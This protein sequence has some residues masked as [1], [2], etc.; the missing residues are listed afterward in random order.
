[1]ALG[2]GTPYLYSFYAPQLL[3]K[4][5]LPVSNL[6]TLSLSMNLGSSLL[7]FFAGMVIDRNVAA[8]CLIGAICTFSAYWILH[9]CYVHELGSVP[10]ISFGLSLVGFG[11]VS[12]Y[13]AAVKCCTTNFPHHRGTA[14]SFP[15]ALYAL[16]G[17][18]FASICTQAF[19]DDIEKIFKFLMWVCSSMIFVGCLTLRIVASPEKVRAKKRKSSVSQHHPNLRGSDNTTSESVTQPI[20]INNSSQDNEPTNSSYQTDSQNRMSSL[21]S[22]SSSSLASSFQSM[23]STKRSDSFLWSKD[24]TGSLS[25]WGWGRVRDENVEPSTPQTP[26]PTFPSFPLSR[27]RP[28]YSSTHSSPQHHRLDSFTKVDRTDSFLRDQTGAIILQR[29]KMNDDVTN[30]EELTR[31]T[32]ETKASSW[33][34][35][36]VFRTI[37][38]P[39]FLVY[40]VILATLQGIGQ[41]YI[42]SVGFIVQTQVISTPPGDYNLNPEKIQSLQV[43]II[44]I[45]SFLGR[46]SSGPVSDLLVK[47]LKAQ[48]IWNIVIAALMFTYASFQMLKNMSPG[49]ISIAEAP[50]NIKNISICSA[51]FGYAFGV[52]FGTFPPVIAD[53]FGTDG[54]STIWGLT[55]SGG[56]FTVKYFCAVLGLDLQRNTEQ[57]KQYCEKGMLCY[58]H[59]FHVT[60]F[61][62][63]TVTLVTL[64]VIGVTHWKRKH[65]N[66]QIYDPHHVEL[67]LGEENEGDEEDQRENIN[68]QV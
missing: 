45:L 9:H 67:I 51:I 1:M 10:L 66:D 20:V 28:S 68:S 12:G 15:V 65:K 35:S 33:R 19:G 30:I 29:N 31:K 25:F 42:Y 52:L 56:L 50:K 4:C 24:L 6:S 48:R 53:A 57:G 17:M 7:G 34:D 41:M 11:S 55:T 21:S 2:A 47:K 23:W 38:K 8:S 32:S 49:Q 14:G 18:L 5:N 44:S 27:A 3:A 13:F 22:G 62:A 61:F 64:I 46:L 40:F 36:H 39:R 54:F 59:T 26:P 58:T 43:S 37:Q 16:S 60:A 63:M